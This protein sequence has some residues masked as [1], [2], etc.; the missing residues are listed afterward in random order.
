M[1]KKFHHLV[2]GILVEDSKVLLAKA[3]G[4]HVIFLPGGHIEIGESAKDA[5]GREFEEELGETCIVGDFLG[6]VEHKWEA[7]NVFHYE[8]NQIFEIKSSSL[9]RNM[10]PI[11]VESHLDFFWCSEQVLNH[12]ELQPYPFREYIKK[13]INGN[14]G[15]LWA[16]TL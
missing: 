12:T 10:N 13:L 4:S 8:V 2:R 7:N 9:P 16:S 11:S 6:V 5:L 1:E 3:K 15:V 14:K